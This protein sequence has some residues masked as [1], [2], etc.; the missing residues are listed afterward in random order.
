M[1]AACAGVRQNARH[2]AIGSMN[3]GFMA[4]QIARARCSI[5]G[6]WFYFIRLNVDFQ[7]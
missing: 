4:S 3:F 6:K 7:R 5:Q 2:K 1:K